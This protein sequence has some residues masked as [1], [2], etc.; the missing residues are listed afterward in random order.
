MKNLLTKI[1]C[2]IIAIAL[3]VTGSVPTVSVTANAAQTIE[4]RLITVGGKTVTNSMKIADVKELFGEPK[5]VTTSYW[6]GYAYT[7]YGE[8]Y[9]DYLYLETY[10]DGTIACYGSVSPRFE[11]NIYNYGDKT[12]YYVRKGCEATD[13][14]NML[15]G[16]IYY[17]NYHSDAYEV[18][19]DNLTENSRNLCKH[20]VEMW[21][22]VSYLYGFDTPT[23]FDEQLFNISAQLADNCSDLYD[24]C[25][26]TGQDS[27]YQLVS[28]SSISFSNYNYPNLLEFAQ[29]GRNYKCQNGN[30][31][32]FMYYPRS[33]SNN[34][35]T[36]LNGFVNKELLADWEP[37]LYTEREKELLLDSRNYYAKSV[38]SYNSAESYYEIEP[39]YDSIDSIE[40]GKLS[41]GVAAGAADYLNA[42]RVGGGL[43]P[44]EYSEELSMD[45]QCKSTYT[46]YL[47]ENN[48]S[49]LNPHFPPQVEGLSDEYYARCQSGSGENLFMC[50]ILSTSIIGSIT[51]AL[52]DSYG[53]GQYYSRGHRYN[54]LDPAWKYIGVGNTLQQGCHKM[55]GSQSYDVD[56]VS[57]P[58]NGIT[59][60]ESGFSP[61]GMWTCQFYN[62]LSPTSDT[63]VTI[64]CLNS[65]AV[66]N[67]DPNNLLDSQD[68]QVN[69][70][71][72]SYKDNSIAFKTGGVYEITYEH[73]SDSKG[74]EASYSYRTVYENA[75]VSSDGAS[76]PQEIKL[77]K[78][79]V[80]IAVDTTRKITAK[81]EP[82]SVENK[83]IY[84]TSDNPSVATVN[85]CGEVTAHALGT[86]VITATSESG[87]ITSTC[88]ITVIETQE[89][90]DDLPIIKQPETETDNSDTQ[91]ENPDVSDNNDTKKKQP[92]VTVGKAKIKSAKKK[93]TA[94]SLTITLSKKVSQAAGYQVKVYSSVKKA[95]KNKGAI[96]T[97]DVQKNTKKII[98]TNK[99]LKNKKG[100]YVRVRAYR[101]VKEKKKYGAWS[102]VK[103]VG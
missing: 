80:K 18:F 43:N 62:S 99:K 17:T 92:S 59:I 51:Y 48:I 36:V 41:E 14:D 72:I 47:S 27:C 11:T 44:L 56:V 32:G 70:S 89:E 83:R 58:A 97:K 22:A 7:F 103:K 6:G 54:L 28:K 64:K 90:A 8:D 37:V 31:I 29:Y 82:A 53:S 19:T 98:V 91:E 46:V 40:G 81:I 73:L 69:G 84:F 50:G 13:Y 85:E 93:K 77:D 94:K 5:L 52:D 101:K 42:I 33:N 20:A 2:Y 25:N 75:Y 102:S 10:S 26:S 3:I 49:N 1:V 88:E 38:E 79:S 87:N 57:W 78:T 55:T 15:Y 66:W 39:S 71:L 63:T 35:Y 74:N 61:S 60:S 34:G 67:I 100:L 95:K 96:V 65:G 76:E 86:A 24:Y 45:A 21:N 9:S 12:D 23:Y 68:Y 4:G 16:V 30:A